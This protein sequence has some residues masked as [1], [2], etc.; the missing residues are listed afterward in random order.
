MRL[1]QEQTVFLVVLVGL[2]LLGYRKL[3][4]GSKVLRGSTRGEEAVFEDYPV[5]E[6][7]VGLPL[8]GSRPPLARE[9]FSPPRD[10]RPLPPLAFVEPPRAA[11]PALLPP[12][13]PGPRARAFGD[14]LRRD[15]ERRDVPD[16]FVGLEAGEDLE[17]DLAFL[18]AA[19]EPESRPDVIDELRALESGEGLDP[20]ADESP[21]ERFSRIEAYKD[22]YDWIVPFEGGLPLFG[23]IENEERYALKTDEARQE[24]PVRFTQ[25]D[26]ESGRAQ[27]E[28]FGDPS[29]SHE[30]ASI[31]E[32]EF[33]R[34]VANEIELRALAIG[35]EL[36][37]RTYGE[38]LA[39]G[40]YCIRNRHA[41][42]RALELAEELFTRAVAFD[43]EDPE[44]R[45]GLARC[46][47]AGFDFERAFQEYRSLLEA[48][49]HRPEIHVRM[50]QLEARFLL[51]EQAEER[52]RHALT[53]DRG[54]W[55]AQWALGRFL[56]EDGRLEEGIGFLQQAARGAPQDPDQL[57]V[58]VGI[59][60]DLASALL[61]DGQVAEA[62]RFFA[63]A[64][65]A[66]ADNQVALAGQI[67]TGLYGESAS[68]APGDLADGA[69][70]GFELALARGIASLEAGDFEV[71][72]DQ[73]L[74]AAESDPLRADRALAALSFLAEVSGHPEEARRFADDALE[75]HPHSA[76]ALYQ[77]G[78]L[79][80]GVDDYEGAR[81]SLLQA[82]EVELDFED[83]LV[84]LG[85][86]AFELGRFEDAERYLE[87]AVGINDER[88]EVH[89]LRGMNA[90]RLGAVADADASFERA[91]ELVSDHPVALAGSA[92]CTY[93]AGDPTEAMIRL[94]DIDDSRR[95]LPEDDPY[96]LWANAQLERLRDHQEKVVWSDTFNRKRLMNSWLT[97]EGDGVVAG[98][99]DGAV[100]IQ[101]VFTAARQVSVY[102]E[103]PASI[104][105]SLEADL[106]FPEVS[107]EYAN[108]FRAGILIARERQRRNAE[109]EV[110]GEASVS[111]H[112]DGG[113]QLRF[114]RSGRQPEIVD[115]Q[116]P[117][118]TGRWVRLSIVRQGESSQS[119][120]TLSLDG[121]PLAEGVPLPVVGSGTTSPLVVGL[122]AEGEEGREVL[123]KM[124]NVE[125]VYRTR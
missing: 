38:A 102:R 6:V 110:M 15:F 68:D 90:L 76:F 104:F 9:L 8:E 99:E 106:W 95:Q 32:F 3:T 37:R 39:L 62:R 10:T 107:G 70:A 22:R 1:R 96:R 59:R 30:R 27:F 112:K 44:P 21:A 52:L 94:A 51:R 42:A 78:R 17:A 57:H 63:Q 89:A 25:I 36:T 111:R 74:L 16:L 28:N 66:D 105:V 43:P 98:M 56:V 53:V 97:R 20:F 109:A 116:Q 117:F 123:V 7:E 120:V 82:L 81:S 88:P 45:L 85:E 4:S 122:F 71:A 47:E 124:D 77:K 101:G 19:P 100:K 2:G 23:R 108:N 92:W 58:R 80:G 50:A 103:Y 60:V 29:I 119:T 54:S 24:E 41:A 5:P 125:V 84:A 14:L 65:S 49:A 73:L 26:P 69:S 72:L 115:M 64:L 113:V 40:D 75:V 79:L 34:T 83:A 114:V 35:P 55:L 46:F 48:F 11:L 18:D 31:S 87:R 118:P 12:T 67:A 13:E 33:A 61:A 86:M 91:L 93:L 121:V